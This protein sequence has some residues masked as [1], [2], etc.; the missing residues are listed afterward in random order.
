MMTTATHNAHYRVTEPVFE[1]ISIC[2][3]SSRGNSP[4]RTRSST[5]V[6]CG[7]TMFIAVSSTVA[8]SKTEAA[9]GRWVVAL[10]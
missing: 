10:W 9:Y 8:A 1:F 3:R 2:G 6:S 7:S 5:G 4:W